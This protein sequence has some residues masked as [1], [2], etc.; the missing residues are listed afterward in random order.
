MAHHLLNTYAAR[1]EP[2]T[3]GELVVSLVIVSLLTL[4]SVVIL[5]NVGGFRDGF[6]RRVLTQRSM[7]SPDRASVL[8]PERTKSATRSLIF[9]VTVVLLGEIFFLGGLLTE[10]M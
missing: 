6:V 9:V 5:A 4:W 10:F 7:F 2:P 8:T 3:T 1:G